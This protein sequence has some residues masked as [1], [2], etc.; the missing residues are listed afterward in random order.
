MHEFWKLKVT[1]KRVMERYAMSSYECTP[2][3][4]YLLFSFFVLSLIVPN[5]IIVQAHVQIKFPALTK[6]GR[7]FLEF[8]SEQT[9][10]VYP[11]ADM[12]LSMTMPKSYSKFSDWGKGWADPE[13]RRQRLGKIRHNRKQSKPKGT[14]RSQK[15]PK[16][17]RKSSKK[18]SADVTTVRGRIAAKISKKKS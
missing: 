17:R 16:F 14:R 15:S 8:N 12:L 9:L 2:S 10:F 6:K 1:S 18:R 3:F 7:D 5:S 13:I 11:E 4:P